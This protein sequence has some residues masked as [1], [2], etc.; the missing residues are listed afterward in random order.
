MGLLAACGLLSSTL[1]CP[2][3]ELLEAESSPKLFEDDNCTTEDEP[4]SRSLPECEWM[5][6]GDSLPLLLLG[7]PELKLGLFRGL[8]EEGTPGGG[9]VVVALGVAGP[10]VLRRGAGRFCKSGEFRICSL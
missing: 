1:I 6:K 8:T 5:S 10:F 9:G 7:D 3:A 2:T 4:A